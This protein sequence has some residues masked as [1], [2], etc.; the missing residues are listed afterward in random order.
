[1]CFQDFS[2]YLKETNY[3]DITSKKDIFGSLLIFETNIKKNID[4]QNRIDY[5]Y[6][7]SILTS[8]LAFSTNLNMTKKDEKE[9]ALKMQSIDELIFK[10][11]KEHLSNNSEANTVTLK[12]LV[13]QNRKILFRYINDVVK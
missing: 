6:I 8:I 3:D 7:Y 5:Q 12:Y 10:L 4:S 1:M 11:Y 9:L 2:N 13:L